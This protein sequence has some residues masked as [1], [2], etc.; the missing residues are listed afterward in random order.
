M[1]ISPYTEEK[2]ET[3]NQFIVPAVEASARAIENAQ[4]Q[5]WRRVP[6]ILYLF[7]I[8]TADGADSTALLINAARNVAGRFPISYRLYGF[9]KQ[10]QRAGSGAN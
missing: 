8:G 9:E 6:E 7:A 3:F 4:A 1:K 2:L 5:Q 10:R